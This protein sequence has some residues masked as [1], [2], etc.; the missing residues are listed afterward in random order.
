MVIF[1]SYVKLPEG[2]WYKIVRPLTGETA[3][4]SM[5]MCIHV[6]RQAPLKRLDSH[7]SI[8]APLL[9]LLWYRL[10]GQ[11]IINYQP[12]VFQLLSGKQKQ[13]LNLVIYR[14]LPIRNGDFPYLC[15]RLPE[16]RYGDSCS[17]GYQ[18][19]ASWVKTIWC[20]RPPLRSDQGTGWYCKA[21]FL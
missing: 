7:P 2:N 15:K 13:L 19:V 18:T 6:L 21:S 20:A 11:F 9:I 16:G 1:N 12:G 8:T 14:K 4:P 10:S 5:L 17:W 3:P